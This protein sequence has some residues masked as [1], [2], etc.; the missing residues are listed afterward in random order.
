[1]SATEEPPRHTITILDL[2]EFKVSKVDWQVKYIEQSS[3][4]VKAT[5]SLNSS[6]LV[7]TYFTETKF[8]L[9][10]T[11][12]VVV[13]SKNVVMTTSALDLHIEFT[14]GSSFQPGSYCLEV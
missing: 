11:N 14:N 9:I 4:L 12:G 5:L 8:A 10:S 3:T 7:S 6:I 13:F 2:S 1:M